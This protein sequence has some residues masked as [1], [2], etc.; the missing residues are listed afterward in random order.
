[1]EGEKEIAKVAERKRE[2]EKFKKGSCQGS[3]DERD[4]NKM[5]TEG[6]KPS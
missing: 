1:M 3:S 5:L 4:I 2:R 6:P